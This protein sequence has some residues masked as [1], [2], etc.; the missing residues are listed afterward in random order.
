V[1]YDD[2]SHAPTF[3]SFVLGHDNVDDKMFAVCS[4]KL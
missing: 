4:C 2:G 3:W 1:I